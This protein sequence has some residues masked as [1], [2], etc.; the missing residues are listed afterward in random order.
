MYIN[1]KNKA[2]INSTIK[3]LMVISFLHPL[4]FPDKIKYDISGILSYQQIF[5]LHFGQ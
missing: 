1:T 3:Y 2:E 5:F 4:H